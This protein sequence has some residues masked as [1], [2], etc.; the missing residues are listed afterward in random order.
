M[1]LRSG[2]DVRMVDQVSRP[3]QSGVSHVG[4][5]VTD[6][7]RSISFYCDVLGAVV[8]RRPFEGDRRPFSGRT[9]ILILGT[10]VLDLYQHSGN[11][12]ETFEPARTGLDHLAFIAKSYEELDAWARWLDSQAIPHSDVRYSQGSGL[13]DFVDPDGIQIEFCHIE[14]ELLL[15]ASAAPRAQDGK[16]AN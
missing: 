10:T 9:A 6:L 7:D 2:Q 3:R 13:F 1:T 16:R 11:G 14:Q 8:V 15:R 5:S 12:T 4:L